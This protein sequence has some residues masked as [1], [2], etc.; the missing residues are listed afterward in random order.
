MD[1]GLKT[2]LVYFSAIV[3]LFGL[4][5]FVGLR[6][7]QKFLKSNSNNRVSEILHFLPSTMK[8]RGNLIYG[9]FE[10]KNAFDTGFSVRN[11]DNQLLGEVIHRTGRRSEWLTISYAGRNF[12]ASTLNTWFQTVVLKDS[13]LNSNICVFKSFNLR[14]NYQI[15]GVGILESR[16]VWGIELLTH[17]LRRLTLDG[18]EVG[19]VCYIANGQINVPVVSCSERIPTVIK[20]FLLEMR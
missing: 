13:E 6:H 9:L 5:I 3:P 2:L 16:P 1:S 15:P 11:I 7:R 18:Q 4:V 8:S 10:D 12:Q 20:M 19:F 17:G 14:N